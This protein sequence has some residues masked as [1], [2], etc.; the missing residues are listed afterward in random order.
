MQRHLWYICTFICLIPTLINPARAQQPQLLMLHP[1]VAN[2][3]SI[4]W[5][6]ENDMISLPNL[7]I[8]GVYYAF[9]AYDY[10]QTRQLIAEKNMKKFR[11]VELTDSIKEEEVYTK[12]AL[13]DDFHSLFKQSSG[14]LFFGGPDLP[15]S[16]Y[17]EKTHLLTSIYDP[18]RHFME[19][20]FAAHLLGTSRNQALKPLLKARPDFVVYGF[21]LGMQT[22]NVAAGGTMIQDIPLEIYNIK[23]K[24]DAAGQAPDNRHRNYNKRINYYDH[25]LS[26]Y[27]HR[28]KILHADVAGQKMLELTPRVLSNHH[29]AVENYG[30]GLQ[31]AGESMDGK[32]T[33]A[34]MHQ[35]FPHVLGVQFHPEP[36]YIYQDEVTFYYQLGGEK[37]SGPDILNEDKSMDFHKAFWQH[38]SQNLQKAAQ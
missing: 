33:E 30:K 14:I 10:S 38:F 8:T 35:D 3:N 19:V 5:L 29:Q 18:Q 13:S 11:L 23:H 7:K 2:V 31:K 26:G 28:V 16:L 34:L 1:T 20:S 24:E 36:K 15:P 32:I 9:E 27:F 22:L 37:L 12:N 6:I 25:L 17:N 4:H 21:C